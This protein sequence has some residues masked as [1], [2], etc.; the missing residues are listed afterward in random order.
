MK[1]VE[2]HSSDAINDS[3]VEMAKVKGY[4]DIGD[5]VVVTAGIPSPNVEMEI[6]SADT[7]MMRVAVV[8]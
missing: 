8:E 3:A 1:S 7:H 6:R 5:V 2:M 4:A